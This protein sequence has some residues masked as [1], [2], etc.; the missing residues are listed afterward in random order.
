[1]WNKWI[2]MHED[3]DS[4][5]RRQGNYCKMNIPL[6]AAYEVVARFRELRHHNNKPGRDRK[7]KLSQADQQYLRVTSLWDHKK[8]SSQ[9][10]KN[11]KKLVTPRLV[12]WILTSKGLHGHI[13]GRKPFLW[14]G[15]KTRRWPWA[16]YHKEWK[17]GTWQ[18]ALS[19]FSVMQNEIY[20][21]SIIYSNTVSRKNL[22]PQ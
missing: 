8:S 4:K 6:R 19:I 20:F 7:K 13:A 18:K 17:L 21:V 22:F 1:M 3:V 12:C 16:R 9:L 2:I 10:E 5:R 14:H 11:R 15:N